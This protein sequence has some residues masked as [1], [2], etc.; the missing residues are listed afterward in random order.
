MEETYDPLQIEARVQEFWSERSGFRVPAALARDKC[1]GLSRQ[2]YPIGRVPIGHVR[3]YA[4]ADVIARYQ[5]MQGRKVRQPLVGW[6]ALAG[7]SSANAAITNETAPT[8][9]PLADSPH[10]T[11]QP[12]GKVDPAP[13]VQTYGADTV[14]LFAVSNSPPEQSLEWSESGVQGAQ[15]FLRKLWRL[16]Y[17]HTLGGPT[18]PLPAMAL[19]DEA[20]AMRRRTHKTIAKVGDDIGRR[21]TVNTAIAAI[22]EL[23]NAVIEFD[24]VSDAARAVTQEALESVVLMLSPTAPHLMQVLWESLGRDGMLMNEPWPTVDQAAL[25]RD[26]V[27]LV[28]QV[29]GKLRGRIAVPVE[30]GRKQ[31]EASALA[32]VNVSRFTEGKQIRKVILVPGKLVS[33]VVDG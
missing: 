17:R 20:K 30:A 2:P 11:G 27:E 10:G 9:R 18:I 25:V 1:D 19:D 14:C 3:S 21:H 5:R 28:V 16:V 12:Q 24:E 26:E 13:M 29:N 22:M 23:V 4:I 6:D 15:R 32:H 7:A 8:P 31:M 33:V